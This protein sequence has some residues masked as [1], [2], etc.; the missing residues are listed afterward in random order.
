MDHSAANV[1]RHYLVGAGYGVLR[2][3]TPSGLWPIFTSR[4]PD[5]IDRAIMISNQ[6]GLMDGRNL[7]TGQT[8]TH[9]GLQVLIR[10]MSEEDGYDKAFAIATALDALKRETVVVNAST[11]IIQAVTRKGD[12]IPLGSGTQDTELERKRFVHTLN[13]IATIRRVS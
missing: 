6:S 5:S 13:A 4:L 10:D 1:I 8:I 12:I 2:T 11:Y 3:T 9:P 7:R